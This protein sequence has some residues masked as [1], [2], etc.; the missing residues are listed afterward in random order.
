MFTLTLVAAGISNGA[1]YALMALGLVLVYKTQDMVNFAHGELFMAGAFLGYVIY[2]TFG[3][4]Y[5][6]A[7]L[8]AMVLSALI[9]AIVE[10]IT[11]R[12]ISNHPH[13]TLTM[14]TVG[15]SYAMKGVARLFFGG[16][17]LSMPPAAGSAPLDVGGVPVSPQGILNVCVAIGLT[18]ILLVLF[19]RTSLGK[20]IRATQQ[21]PR[22]ARVIG[23]DTGRIYALTWA[24]AA[25][26]GAAAGF[27]AAPV[28][29][30]YPDMGT[31]FLLK[32]IAAA[33]LGGFGSVGGAICGGLAIGV[34]ETLAGG[35]LSTKL[36]DVS[37]YLV[38]IVVMMLRPEGLFGR[39]AVVRV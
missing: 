13:V 33:V 17:I 38:I 25:M 39:A 14:V 24:L 36:M 5:P 27:L 28:T 7:F 16:D 37:S 35:F 23:I 3:L 10:L 19:Q 11:I 22:G 2:Q 21:N 30:I 6:A 4:P 34:I 31:R 12:P 29:L 18:V 20:Q 26:M 8:V 9:G 32:A 15:V 1:L